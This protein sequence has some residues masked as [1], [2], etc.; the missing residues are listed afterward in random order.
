MVIGLVTIAVGVGTAT[1]A[2]AEPTAAE[3]ESQLDEQWR[4]IEPIIEEY[5]KVVED[6]KKLRAQADA[7]QT[8]LQP[9]SEQVDAVMGNVQQIAISAYKGG[10]MGALNALLSAHSP[11]EMADQLTRL[12]ALARNQRR[13]VSGVAETRDKYADE[14]KA[15]DETI[16]KQ[17]KHEEELAAKKKDIEA[18]IAELEKLQRRLYGGGGGT[19]GN[20]TLGPCPGATP[21]NAQ[22]LAA[23]QRACAQMGKPYVFAAEGPN[24]FD[25]SGLT[26]YA[27]LAGGH[28]LT[29]QSVSQL[30]ET[31]R[32]TKDELLPGD[33]I[34]FYS[35]TAPSHVGI[36]V[37]GGLM[38]HASR[39]G[40]PV[41]QK[42]V[43][44]DGSITA[45]GRVW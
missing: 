35:T 39:A 28:T 21:P 20:G 9:L 4:V 25:C 29:H 3:I 41:R 43:S 30:K 33:L 16:A 13:Q 1:H 6:L 10:R 2:H 32:I 42:D 45:Y 23:V 34:F 40:V 24:A 18:K 11:T 8:Q 44:K 14:K 38:V 37:G 27:W 5:N 7:L 36:Y 22:A 17:A 12:E 31:R 19:G 15:L 26:K